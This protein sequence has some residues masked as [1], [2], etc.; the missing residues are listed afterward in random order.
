M[1]FFLVLVMLNYVF[2]N[3]LD[4]TKKTKCQHGY[5]KQQHPED[6]SRNRLLLSSE[7]LFGCPTKMKKINTN[8]KIKLNLIVLS[9]GQL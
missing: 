3:W 1:M 8:I 5:E 9:L 7:K 2:F 6:T 4:T